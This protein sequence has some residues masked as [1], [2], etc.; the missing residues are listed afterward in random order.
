MWH[1]GFFMVSYLLPNTQ[2]E[3]PPLVGWLWL[4]IQ[5]TCS[6]PQYLEGFSIHNLG[7]NHAA[8]K[9]DPL[10]MVAALIIC[11]LHFPHKCITAYSQVNT[12]I[13]IWGITNFTTIITGT[14]IWYMVSTYILDSI[15][16]S[17]SCTL[18]AK[19]GKKELNMLSMNVTTHTH[20][21]ACTPHRLISTSTHV[22]WTFSHAHLVHVSCYLFHSVVLQR[23]PLN[24]TVTC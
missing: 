10:N 5:Y 11:L 9:R 20:T 23:L 13:L 2:A 6:Y 7:M 4:L 16:L 24:I 14:S 3:G 1:A 18:L 12:I 15:S 19:Y 17:S 8:V 21:C 22:H